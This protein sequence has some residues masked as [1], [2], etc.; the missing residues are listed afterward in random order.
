MSK[1]GKLTEKR[2]NFKEELV[3]ASVKV[4]FMKNMGVLIPMIFAPGAI[5]KSYRRAVS[6]M[7]ELARKQTKT[8]KGITGWAKSL[9][10]LRI[11]P[12]LA[13][14]LFLYRGE[15]RKLVPGAIRRYMSPMAL[16]RWDVTGQPII[17]DED[18]RVLDGQQ[19]LASVIETGIPIVVLVVRGIPANN[20]KYM[21][22]GVA[23]NA[24]H[25][26]ESYRDRNGNP[27]ES[28]ADLSHG[29]TLAIR[30]ACA[31]RDGKHN[32]DRKGMEPSLP[33]SVF[34]EHTRFTELVSWHRES[35]KEFS[36]LGL[37]P[38]VSI[39]AMFFTTASN[40]K[41]SS[42]FW[43]G[44]ATGINLRKTSPMLALRSF[45]IREIG[46]EEKP[47]SSM[48]RALAATAT[49]WNM[50]VS[51]ARCAG[52][53]KVSMDKGKPFPFFKGDGR[54]VASILK[55]VDGTKA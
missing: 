9:P 49:A 26:F 14:L 47:R 5:K 42:S 10:F 35:S 1:A 6:N 33:R 51:G 22:N 27:L 44:V 13:R 24:R 46:A 16:S 43:E 17:L 45:L 30:Y 32:M 36:A 55:I 21:D 52:R 31:K 37:T 18:D 20:F 2:W 19:R 48:E 25:Q 15:N 29:V 23:R 39:C 38:G 54:A 3:H 28:P 34:E 8:P 41:K 53:L 4:K 12:E 11:T 40:K 50:H 7:L